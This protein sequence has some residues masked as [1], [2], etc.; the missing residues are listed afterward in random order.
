MTHMRFDSLERSLS[1][2]FVPVYRRG[3]LVQVEHRRNDRLA[4]ALL[5]GRETTADDLRRSALSR[6]EHRL[7]LAELDKARAAHAEA[8]K[9]ADE[10]LRAEIDR[11]VGTIE[12]RCATRRGPRITRL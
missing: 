5:G 7:D 9:A 12:E 8:H 10:A 1:G 2:S 6:R 4:I 3:K 11:L